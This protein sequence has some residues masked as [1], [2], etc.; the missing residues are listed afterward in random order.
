MLVYQSELPR[1]KKKNSILNSA[2]AP[3]KIKVCKSTLSGHLL[4]TIIPIQPEFF[5]HFGEDSFM[6]AAILGWPTGKPLQIATGRPKKK[7]TF[8]VADH[9]AYQ[10]NPQSSGAP[11]TLPIIHP[12]HLRRN[13]SQWLESTWHK[14]LHI[15][16][17]GPSTVTYILVPVPYIFTS[18]YHLPTETIT[19]PC[20]ASR[21]KSSTP[22]FF[23][24]KSL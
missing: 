8:L 6:M 5:G 24:A 1:L 21:I 17:Y 4:A 14:C 12:T 22:I 9:W 18:R 19:S 7:Y 10:S 2:T 13:K 11:W 3:W 15:G 23:S 20:P 16:W